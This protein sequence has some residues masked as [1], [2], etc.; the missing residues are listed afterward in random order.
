M[1]RPDIYKSAFY[2]LKGH[3]LYMYLLTSELLTYTL[4]ILVNKFHEIVVYKYLI[5]I[6]Y[7]LIFVLTNCNVI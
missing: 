6:L 4:Q 1:T 3:T 7:F 5:I 2:S